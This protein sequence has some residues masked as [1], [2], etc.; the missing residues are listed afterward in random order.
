MSS[1]FLCVFLPIISILSGNKDMH[2]SLGEFEF[3]PDQ[4]IDYGLAS[5]CVSKIDVSTFSR[6]LLIQLFLKLEHIILHEFGVWPDGTT[7]HGV[8]CP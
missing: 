4:T 2:L 3:Q 7:D 8:I 6:L 1:L 5:H